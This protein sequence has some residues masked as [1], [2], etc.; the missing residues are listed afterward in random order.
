ML[1]ADRMDEVSFDGHPGEV[2]LGLFLGFQ[3]PVELVDFFRGE[4][5]QLH[6]QAFAVSSH[7]AVC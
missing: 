1:G 2:S 5:L 6:R 7:G 3:P 4:R